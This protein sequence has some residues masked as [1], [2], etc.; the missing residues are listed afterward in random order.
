MW[1]YPPMSTDLDSAT[2]LAVRR[3]A[4]EY[5][6]IPY[7]SLPY[8]LTRPA[9]V[10][11]IAQTFGLALPDVTTAR[12]LEIGCAGG[13]N[14][15]PL[16]AAF[17]DARFVGIDLSPVQIGQARER[18]AA[19]GLENIEF[20]EGSVTEIDHGWGIFDYIVCHGVYS[21]VPPEVQEALLSALRRSL[22]PEGVAYMSYNVYPGW[23]A[24]EI[25]RDAMLLA[26]GDSATSDEKVREARH[27]RLP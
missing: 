17:P 7:R 18:A 22:A 13:G 20:R 16:A 4:S 1:Q 19:A 6:R 12:V 25:V 24:K 10:A 8:P 5:D 11:A 21:W 26:S 27:G 23:K 3:T 14:I 2:D 15:I 9:H